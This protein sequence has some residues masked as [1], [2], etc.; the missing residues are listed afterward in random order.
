[1]NAGTKVKVRLGFPVEK[2]EAAT[3]APITADMLPIPAGW[4][5]VRF[6]AD[7]ALSLIHVSRMVAA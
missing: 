7:R 2:W 6:A 3:V 1:M 5:P 4:L